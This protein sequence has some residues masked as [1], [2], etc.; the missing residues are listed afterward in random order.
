MLF[1]NIVYDP[2]PEMFEVYLNSLKHIT[3][4]EI[5]CTKVFMPEYNPNIIFDIEEC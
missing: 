2:S 1:T 3:V 4:L 5:I